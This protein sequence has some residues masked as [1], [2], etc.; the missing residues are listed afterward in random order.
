MQIEGDLPSAPPTSPPEALAQQLAAYAAA[1]QLNRARCEDILQLMQQQQQQQAPAPAPVPNLSASTCKMLKPSRFK[2][3]ASSVSDW[4][5]QMEMYLVLGNEPLNL[6][7]SC[8]VAAGYLVGPALTWWR[9]CGDN[10]PD[11]QHFKAELLRRF[12][13]FDVEEEARYRLD[14]LR[15]RSSVLRYAEEFN[16]CMV[17][18]PTMDEK[19]RTHRFVEGLKPD[20]RKWIRL[21]KPST[22]AAAISLAA[23]A[24]HTVWAGR[25]STPGVVDAGQQPAPM[26]LDAVH[27]QGPTKTGYT[28]PARPDQSA[29]VCWRCGQRGHRR[30]ECRN[31][32]AAG[33]KSDARRATQSSN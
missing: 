9:L 4:L 1:A 23:H 13:A 22:L 27:H 3:D 10:I 30:Y 17:E 12:C 5:H 32:P 16:K 19:D 6:R 14:R 33:K 7:R 25:F 11:W 28:R 8:V 29:V 24:D 31:A 20:V 26:E 2:G 15:Q 21:Q 18:L